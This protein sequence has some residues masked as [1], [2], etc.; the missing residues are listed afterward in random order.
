[1]TVTLGVTPDGRWDIDVPKLVAATR[2][3]GLSS[4]GLPLRWFD[5]ATVGT[6][7]G[8]GLGC[9]E[10]MALTITDDDERVLR[11]AA[12]IAEAAAAMQAPWVNTTFT[13]PLNGRTAPLIE[14]C[15]AMFA[16]AGSGMAAEF[17]PLGAVSSLNGALEIVEVAG[18]ERAGV[19]IDTWHFFRG[20]STWE[21]LERLPLD[22]IAFIQFSDAPP[23]ISDDGMDETTNRRTLP[24]DGTFELERF[25][26]TLLGR[27][28]EGLVSAEILSAELRELPVTAV[29]ESIHRA[30][31]RYWS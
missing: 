8:A 27:G 20:D 9:H 28:F 4:L 14:R 19:Q 17:S 7:E 21:Q 10:M 11:F 31:T 2:E 16:E 29:L 26:S 15:A 22:R 18:R 1:M 25:A 12:R 24:G 23:P 5:D 13:E 3:A 30:M 6:F